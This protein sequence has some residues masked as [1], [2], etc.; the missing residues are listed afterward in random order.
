MLS[1]PE[2]STVLLMIPKAVFS[3]P[4]VFESF[5]DCLDQSLTESATNFQSEIQLVY[6]H[7]LFK[8]KDKDEQNFFIFDADGNPLGLSSELSKPIDYSRRSPYPIINILRTAQVTAVQKSVPEGRI[9]KQNTERLEQVG[10]AA[11]DE[12]LRMRNWKSLPVHSVHAK[13]YRN[14]S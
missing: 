5:C 13:M 14:Q 10:V 8:F 6:F 2:I 7:P 12:M 1:D 11:L 4:A 9:I 3:E